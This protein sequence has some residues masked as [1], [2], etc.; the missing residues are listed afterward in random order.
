MNPKFD[1]VVFDLA[2]ADAYEDDKNDIAMLGDRSLS[3]SSSL[4]HAKQEIP[5]T[6]NSTSDLKVHYYYFFLQCL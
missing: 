5:S 2:M 1:Q 3:S 6:V 4:S